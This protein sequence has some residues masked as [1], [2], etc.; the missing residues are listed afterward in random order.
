[1]AKVRFGGK[2]FDF[3]PSKARLS[4]DTPTDVTVT[5]SIQV[6][7]GGAVVT[8]S[9]NFGAFQLPKNALLKKVVVLGSK[10]PIA[11]G[12]QSSVDMLFSLGGSASIF[13]KP[14]VSA[15]TALFDLSLFKSINE[16]QVDTSFDD[17]PVFIPANTSLNPSA[18]AYGSFALNDQFNAQMYLFFTLL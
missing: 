6:L 5:G 7:A 10:T 11:T 2:E 13:Y 15:L 18:V 3:N 16:G 1:M 12:V 4:K 8:L 9:Q 14:P 17:D